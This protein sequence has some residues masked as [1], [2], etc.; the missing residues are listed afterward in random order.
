MA[1]LVLKLA[2]GKFV[3]DIT[4][5]G[6]LTNALKTKVARCLKNLDRRTIETMLQ[7][8][9]NQPVKYY[10]PDEHARAKQTSRERDAA[11]LASG[12]KTREQLREE[13]AF[14]RL[15]YDELVIDFSQCRPGCLR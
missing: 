5:C 3:W 10:D 15:D 2:I 13:N 9:V 4:L 11:D 1:A 8:N 12:L 6:V 14:V 7:P